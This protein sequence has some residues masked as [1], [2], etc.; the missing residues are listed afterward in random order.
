VSEIRPRRLAPRGVVEASGFVFDERL[1]GT[2]EARRRIV[3][4]WSPGAEVAR[5]DDLLVLRLA[6]PARVDA[7]VA[8][9]TPLVDEGGALSAA[10]L[11][12]RDREAL[13][14]RP[15]DVVLVTGGV[16]RVVTLA[17]CE[18]ERPEEWIDLAGFRAA[19]AAS[20]GAEP[21]SP[22]VVA[23]PAPFDGRA[24]L[25]GLSPEPAELR[26][27]MAALAGGDARPD[28][29]APGP[30]AWVA[31]FLAYVA[32]LVARVPTARGR[33]GSN[34]ASSV[35]RP[36]SL[37]ERLAARLDRLA[38]WFLRASKLGTLLDRRQAEYVE[39]MMRMFE[40]G[41]LANGLRHAIPL[42]A[43]EG[44]GRPRPAYG[45]PRPRSSLSI[46]PGRG[47]KGASIGMGGE[48]M[49][50]IRELYR[51]AFE[52]LERR[53]RVE[54][55]AF[56]LAELLRADEEAVA[57]LERHGRLKLAAEM[58]EA[59]ELPPGL[60]VR[61]WFVAGERHR[62]VAVARRTGA[63]ADAVLRLERGDPTGAAVLRLI[64]AT[65]L[66][67]AGDYARAVD[68]LWPIEEARSSAVGWMDRA[69]EVGGSSGA[70]MLARRLGEAP[71]DDV[72]ARSLAL[73]DEE[74][75]EGAAARSAFAGALAAGP[76]TALTRTVA[77]AAARAVLRDGPV[78]G[79]AGAQSVYKG[80][81]TMAADGALRSDLPALSS[82]ASRPLRA[83]AEPVR[84]RVERADAG[85]LAVADA[86]FL[87]DGKTLVALGESGARL[88]SRD[89][90]VVASFDEPAH[91]LVVSDHG[92]RALA[93]APRGDVWRLARLD[94]LR[95][96]A[97]GW[98]E[99]LI[100]A[101]ADSYDGSLWF[102]GA[103]GDFY[104]IDTRSREFEALWRVPDTGFRTLA[105]GRDASAVS[106]V[107]SGTLVETWRYEAPALRLRARHQVPLVPEG[108]ARAPSWRLAISAD[109]TV[110]DQTQ[111]T[112][113]S[114]ERGVTLRTY[115]DGAVQGTIA[116]GG[117]ENFSSR[118]SIHAG[119]VAA[120]V[121][122][123][124]GA[125]VRM[126]DGIWG[127]E[128]IDVDLDGARAVSA[129]VLESSVTI[130]DD[131]GR[132]LA[133]D[134]TSGDLLRDLRV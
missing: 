114:G 102:L 59:R 121:V 48:L 134:L 95:R 104:A 36:P 86:V 112:I 89:G 39:R 9:G 129:R 12:A 47:G 61:Q 107:T 69:I 105:V 24:R 93:L 76:K 115:R 10:P 33:A 21:E 18:S 122:S 124:H 83:R 38:L 44:L 78:G 103:R 27:V 72:R 17:L 99:A 42:G 73:L 50:E 1:L 57:F 79:L 45:V 88:L 90:R 71:T 56:V 116:L 41:D 75:T 108:A 35:P 100:D 80:L 123:D 49:E 20:L 70:R 62:A 3:E 53:G 109:G 98:C 58:A 68:A 132:V 87:P 19:D 133:F 94:F 22:R 2:G 130:A 52:M 111:Y 66:A 30:F 84:T 65:T 46:V 96:S 60:V 127:R 40:S 106:F 77:R 31:R 25:A 4:A 74:S 92:D 32:S 119:I 5:V 28:R 131:R 11:E 23:E 125:R 97:E 26:E 91:H 81:V 82:T 13:S 85:T 43:F 126:F 34:A 7:R 67:D 117:Q 29:A 101:W 63:F 110:A 113:P 54:E 55:A 16:A 128:L 14:A 37:A 120:P 118:P 64:W 15:G 51:A 6:R 8:P